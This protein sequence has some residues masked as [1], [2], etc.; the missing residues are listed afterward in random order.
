MPGSLILSERRDP[1]LGLFKFTFLYNNKPYTVEPKP[2]ESN[3]DQKV[4][5]YRYN[6]L[7]DF[8]K[9]V[10]FVCKKPNINPFQYKDWQK[11]FTIRPAGT[12]NKEPLKKDPKVEQ[13]SLFASEELRTWKEIREAYDNALGPNNHHLR[14]ICSNCENTV[15]CRCSTNKVTEYGLCDKCATTY[16]VTKSLDKIA[17][18][19]EIIG[20][21]KE[22]YNIDIVSNTIE[23]CWDW[24]KVNLFSDELQ[25][26]GIQI[27]DAKKVLD[28]AK[29]IGVVASNKNCTRID[30]PTLRQVSTYDCGA[31]ALQMILQYYGI[32]ERE[33]KIM[34]SIHTNTKEGTKTEDII[35]YL[36][37]KGFKVSDGVLT[38]NELKKY[39]DKKIPV[40]V[41]LQAWVDKKTPNWEKGYTNGHYAIVIGYTDNSII[42]SDPSSI[43]ETYLSYDEFLKRWH[44]EGED[45]ERLINYGIV[46]YN[47]KPIYKSDK[48]VPME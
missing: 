39:I 11:N 15:T 38:I 19:L 35:K 36:K 21:I 12:G 1:D 16:T 30:F 42:F 2:L 8:L 17:N 28:I 37:R 46:P 3:E 34:E 22:A 9:Y 5:N 27:E 40:I 18:K 48:I 32:D 23:S 14:L 25:N 24:N 43:N 10:K 20:K 26:Q 6:K 13:M 45:K 29:D 4:M 31:S 44:D 33:E 41:V 7:E 47:K